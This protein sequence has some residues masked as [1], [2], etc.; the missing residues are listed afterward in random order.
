[1]D[2]SKLGFCS[3]DSF[4]V[5]QCRWG[6]R[7]GCNM[8]VVMRSSFTVQ[9]TKWT[10]ALPSQFPWPLITVSSY[11]TA[12]HYTATLKRRALHLHITPAYDLL[13]RQ[14]KPGP[15]HSSLRA[16]QPF[17]IK[18]LRLAYT[19]CSMEYKFKSS[20]HPFPSATT[21]LKL[22]NEMRRSWMKRDCR[23]SCPQTRQSSWTHRQSTPV[24][25]RAHARLE[26]DALLR[27]DRLER[28]DAVRGHA[29][30]PSHVEG[31]VP[32]RGWGAITPGACILNH[33]YL[34]EGSLTSC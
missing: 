1:M 13:T 6:C 29:A 25:A 28:S 9:C 11:C 27:R 3:N 14:L 17:S 15:P 5:F 10:N 30:N 7:I 33:Y 26:V 20:N 12:L 31:D 32:I 34:V 22:T 16:E 4:Y 2:E 8:I 18:R 19:R 23:A 21:S 24:Q